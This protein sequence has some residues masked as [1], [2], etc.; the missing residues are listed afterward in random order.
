MVARRLCRSEPTWRWRRR[1]PSCRRRRGGRSRLRRLLVAAP[2][3][4]WRLLRRRSVLRW[5]LRWRAPLARRGRCWRWRRRSGRVVRRGTLRARRRCACTR[6]SCCQRRAA[7]KAKL[8]G[9]LVGCATPRADDHE[10]DSRELRAPVTLG[11]GPRQQNQGGGC[12]RG[13]S[14][15]GFARKGAKSLGVRGRLGLAPLGRS[16][17]LGPCAQAWRLSTAAGSAQRSF[18]SATRAALPLR[19]RR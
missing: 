6:R 15:P 11:P 12:L 7:R 8:A 5:L 4:R 10:S 1:C 16:A 14:I 3:G 13:R 2:L 18:S 19:S 17:R 9:G